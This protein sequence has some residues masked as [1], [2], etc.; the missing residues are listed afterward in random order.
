MTSKLGAVAFTRTTP[1]L[2]TFAWVIVQLVP[3]FC[4]LAVANVGVSITTRPF[5]PVPPGKPPESIKLPPFALAEPP[6]PPCK[7]SVPPT[8]VPLPVAATTVKLL[9]AVLAEVCVATFIVL[10]APLTNCKFVLF[11]LISPVPELRLRLL[12]PFVEPIL[13]V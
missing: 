5:V 13:T 11:R 7:V 8:P 10:S 2:L 12:A 4:A 9:P 6:V 1:L 3:Q